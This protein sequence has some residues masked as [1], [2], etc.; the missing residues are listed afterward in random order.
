MN[1]T[2][3]QGFERNMKEDLEKN[4][5]IKVMVSIEDNSPIFV[6]KDK[7]LYREGKVKFSLSRY[8]FSFLSTIR[9]NKYKACIDLEY[10]EA[11]YNEERYATYSESFDR[12]SLQNDCFIKE[13][14]EQTS[15]LLGKSIIVKDDFLDIAGTAY[16]VTD[17]NNDG[18]KYSRFTDLELYKVDKANY[19][20][21][22][23]FNNES[24][25]FNKK[26]EELKESDIQV[27]EKE[28]GLDPNSSMY[29][30][31]MFEIKL[32]CKNIVSAENFLYKGKTFMR[33]AA[34]L[35]VD[36][37]SSADEVH[38]YVMDKIKYFDIKPA[39]IFVSDGWC[40][41]EYMSKNHFHIKHWSDYL[42]LKIDFIE[43]LESVDIE[44]VTLTYRPSELDDIRE[45]DENLPVLS[46]IKFSKELFAREEI[47]LY[48]EYAY[49]IDVD[50]IENYKE[51]DGAIDIH[52]VILD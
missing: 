13:I 27:I 26:Y 12:L 33:L 1:Y 8:G 2:K 43:F 49:F 24:S 18:E 10:L 21:R 4:K 34:D 14:V 44:E 37:N 5:D 41:L 3:V 39:C 35:Y 6:V 46:D 42:K 30:D 17:T 50:D 51:Y 19:S 28:L 32:F 9:E 11:K 52:T 16:I 48:G 47:E 38:E 40:C 25:V 29:E 15:K 45:I 20:Y 23:D 7:N 22:E 31:K 36:S